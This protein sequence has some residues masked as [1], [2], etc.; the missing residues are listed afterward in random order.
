[1][2]SPYGTLMGR[3]VI[4]TQACET[5]G[6]LGDIFFCDWKQYLSAIRTTG[7]KTD[8]SIHLWFDYDTVAFRFVLRV[9]GQCWW[10]SAIDSRDGSNTLGAFITLAART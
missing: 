6:D 8:V 5:L 1:A 9:G 3:P 2:G 4:A 10:S 7:I